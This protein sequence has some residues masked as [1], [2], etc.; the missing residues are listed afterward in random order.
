MAAAATAA[1]RRCKGG[2]DGGGDGGGGLGGG[3]EGVAQRRSGG[4]EGGVGRAAAQVGRGRRRRGRRRRGAALGDRR[5]RATEARVA[6]AARATGAMRGLAERRTRAVGGSMRA[7]LTASSSSYRST[8]HDGRPNW[9][10]MPGGS[11]HQSREACAGD[12]HGRATQA[13]PA[14]VRRE[15]LDRLHV[16]VRKD[17][18]AAR[19]V[20]AVERDLEA[21]YLA[22]RADLALRKAPR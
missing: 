10:R 13:R 14:H 9:H 1:G 16:V 20:H 3:E 22:H 8:I 7:R 19:V 4:G 2:G 6:T 12:G 17:E 18:T 15:H 21:H 11:A 5:G